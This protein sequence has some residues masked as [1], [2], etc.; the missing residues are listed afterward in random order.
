MESA[1]EHTP[2]SEQ[3]IREAIQGFADAVRARD[4]E[5]MMSYVAP[6]IVCFDLMPP[7][8]MIGRE[9]YQRSWES[10]LSMMEGD[11]VMETADLDISASGNLAHA[12]ALSHMTVGTADGG[13]VDNWIRWSA[14]FEK[15][16]GKWLLTHEHT[17]WPIDMESGKAVMDLRP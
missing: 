12:H 8:R 6:D 14:G 10:A 5:R 17:S 16:Q 3:Q 4:I 2:S 15:R 11:I 7:L 9:E 1:Q 13:T